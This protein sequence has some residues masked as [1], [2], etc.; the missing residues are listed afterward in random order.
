MVG[1]PAG[2]LL[3]QR[4]CVFDASIIDTSLVFPL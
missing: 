3:Q 1:G 2:L 4:L